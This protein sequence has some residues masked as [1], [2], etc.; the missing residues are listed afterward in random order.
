[1]SR[2]TDLKNHGVEPEPV[3]AVGE[4]TFDLP[5]DYLMEFEVRA[6]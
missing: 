5:M 6:G 1:M 3:F 2:S 4:D